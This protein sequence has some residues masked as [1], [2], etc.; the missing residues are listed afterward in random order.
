[1][2]SMAK[3]DILLGVTG[4]IAAYKTAAL[5]SQLVQAQAGVTVA[6]TGHAQQ[7]VGKLTFGTLTGREVYT[8]LFLSPEVYDA[9]HIDLNRQADLMVVAPATANIIAKLAHGICDDLLST[10]LNSSDC[11]LL[12]APAMNHRMWEHAATQRNI[13]QVRRDGCHIIGPESGQLAC[14]DVGP[15]RMSEPEDIFNR[16]TELLNGV[17]PKAHSC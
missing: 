3:Y 2:S 17:Q 6:M 12:L 13:D 7:F 14:G 16:I 1:M 5:C 11:P 4:G 8:D 10:L 15:G 9:K